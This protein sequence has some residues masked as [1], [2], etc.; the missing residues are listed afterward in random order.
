ML[1]PVADIHAELSRIGDAVAS[2]SLAQP[3]RE[4]DRIT[5]QGIR[6]NFNSS[7]SPDNENWVP[8]KP[9]RGDDGHPLLMDRGPLI[10]AATGGGSGHISRVGDRDV[11]VGVDLDV[12]P[13]ARAH[14]YGYSPRNLPQ[15][16]FLGLRA[17]RVAECEEAI[18]D[19]VLSEVIG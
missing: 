7:A 13:Y 3:L 16:E 10:Q 17:E 8:R 18:G 14:N 11:G 2:A 5:K 12:V 9:R 4:C 15:R 6:D 1:I 19:Y